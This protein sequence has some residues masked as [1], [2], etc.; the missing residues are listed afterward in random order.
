M[1]G[2]TQLLGF[3]PLACK[4]QEELIFIPRLLITRFF[5]IQRDDRYEPS[6][7]LVNEADHVATSLHRILPGDYLRE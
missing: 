4:S 1:R 3:L 5:V 7:Q 6:V 2:Y